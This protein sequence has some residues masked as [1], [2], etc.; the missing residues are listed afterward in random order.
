M[1]PDHWT[2]LI[3]ESTRTVVMD[4]EKPMGLFDQMMLRDE[5]AFEA[6]FQSLVDSL[7]GSR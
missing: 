7:T 6:D 5:A 3:N 2:S 4:G 1:F